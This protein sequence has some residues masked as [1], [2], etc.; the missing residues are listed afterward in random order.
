MGMRRAFPAALTAVALL[1][2]C[3]GGGGGG[4]SDAVD[5][6]KW[7]P[8]T[9]AS[10]E[11]LNLVAFK[12]ALGLDEDADP[13]TNEQLDAV[14]EPIFSNLLP[15]APDSW[16]GYRSD[17]RPTGVLEAVDPSSITAAASSDAEA[18]HTTGNTTV[19]ATTE[20][21]GEI[22]SRLGDLG[23]RDEGGV[24]EHPDSGKLEW[25][26]IKLDEGLVFASRSAE[27]LRAIPEERGED[28]PAALLGKLEGDDIVVSTVPTD[29][30]RE[31]GASVSA[32][33]DAQAGVLV[34]QEADASRLVVV[35][36][37]DGESHSDGEEVVADVEP[38]EQAPGARALRA[39]LIPSYDC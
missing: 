3:G 29:C 28:L 2:G 12:D 4:T 36:G 25:P 6:T 11:A 27:D 1:A 8:S 7:L 19:Y 18:E 34:D 32:D 37:L 39:E 9:T 15:Q 31:S 14:S 23:Y 21:T 16:T 24:L 5:L 38:S 22:G 17:S 26:A 35:G 33:G 20:D 13:R 30:V 10:F